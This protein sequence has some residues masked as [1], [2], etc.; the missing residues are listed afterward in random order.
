MVS[1]SD[2]FVILT[3]DSVT[4]PLYRKGEYEAAVDQLWDGL[5]VMVPLE[6]R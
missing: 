3:G 2:V 4:Y 1:L 5:M 6:T